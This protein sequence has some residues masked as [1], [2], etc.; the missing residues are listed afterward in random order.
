MAMRIMLII[1]LVAAPMMMT[2]CLTYYGYKAMQPTP[3][4]KK[5]IEAYEKA[6]PK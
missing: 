3:E 1:M 5:A 6:N 2:G 4:Q